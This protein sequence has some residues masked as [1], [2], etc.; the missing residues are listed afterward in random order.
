M[1]SIRASK[2]STARRQPRRD[3]DFPSGSGLR[4][5]VAT[6]K[7]YL[8]ERVIRAADASHPADSMLRETLRSVSGLS[9]TDAAWVSHAVFAY[10]RWLGWLDKNTSLVSQI[11]SAFELACRFGKQPESFSDADL[12]QHAVPSWVRAEM[13]VSSD[14]ARALQAEPKLWLRAR[15]GQGTALA[16][17]LGDC[18]IFGPGILADTLIYKGT[19]DLFRTA[20]FHSG[21]LE[22]QDISSQVVGLVCAPHPGQTWWDACAGEGGKLLHLSDLMENKGLIWASDRAAW[23][24]EKLKRRAARARVFNYRAALWSNLNALPTR[25]KF[26]GVLVDAPCSGIGTWHRNPQARWTTTPRDIAELSQLQKELVAKAAEALKPGGKLVYA[27]CTMSRAE[28]SGVTGAFEQEV[29][30]FERMNLASPLRPDV[31][32]GAELWLWPQQFSGNGMF[33]AAWRKI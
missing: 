2:Q 14:W 8:A 33:I 25:T 19:E 21:E 23:R 15:K 27:V 16:A 9:R 20:Q 11:K 22:L 3:G 26:D 17:A 10:Y 32:P 28:T 6:D 24:L 7:G 31:Q 13:E 29:L 18:E 5:R 30:G 4:S 1:R 12:V